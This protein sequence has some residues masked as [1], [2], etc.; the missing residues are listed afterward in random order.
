VPGTKCRTAL[1]A[2]RQSL[3]GEEPLNICVIIGGRCITKFGH[4]WLIMFGCIHPAVATPL[5]S[6]LLCTS[7]VVPLV[8]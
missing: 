1:V 3:E 5:E 6:T 2:D 8:H 4:P 7:D